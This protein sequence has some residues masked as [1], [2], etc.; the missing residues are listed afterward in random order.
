MLKSILFTF[1]LP[2]LSLSAAAQNDSPYAHFG[3]KGRVL[4]LPQ[5]RKQYMLVVANTDTTSSVASVGIEPQKGKYYLFD[6]QN[7]ITGS[8]TLAPLQM[9]RFLSVDPL[10]KSYPW[11]S[12]YAFAENDVIRSIDLDGLEKLI[13]TR[14]DAARRTAILTIKK[15]VEIIRTY[16]LTKDY[17]NIDTNALNAV[18]AK[19]NTTL[20]VESLPENGK[21]VNYIS[22]NAWEAGKG[23]ALDVRYDVN[24][25]V[26]TPDK[27][28]FKG[29][30]G[31]VSIARMEIP[32]FEGK[33]GPDTNTGAQSVTNDETSV[34]D[35][36]LNP[37]FDFRINS[38]TP[39]EVIAHEVGFHNMR[40]RLHP[41]FLNTP[42]Y[43]PSFVAPRL[44]QRVTDKIQPSEKDTKEIINNNL[45]KGRLTVE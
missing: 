19:G 25:K 12:T 8:D 36:S 34:V 15:D 24:A 4:R 23:Y 3:Y 35:I 28:T 31:R 2:L 1:A 37:G 11:N 16:N 21:R 10:A 18:F 42:L 27:A 22:E 17:Q 6:K 32:V 29:D 7:Q 39:E 45:P 33:N 14:V 9:A 13:M 26:V 20:Y 40:G 43:P 38:L 30:N 44:A 5:E 41:S